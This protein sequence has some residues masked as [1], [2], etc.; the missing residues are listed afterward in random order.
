MAY[1]QIHFQY[2]DTY[3]EKET[4]EAIAFFTSVSL[5][6]PGPNPIHISIFFFF[7]GFNLRGMVNYH[8]TKPSIIY[9]PR[10]HPLIAFIIA[11]SFIYGAMPM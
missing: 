5:P 4:I 3:L 8:V 1:I 11:L 6:K 7:F 10:A 9:N 2:I